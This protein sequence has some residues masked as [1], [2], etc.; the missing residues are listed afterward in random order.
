[1]KVI[2]IT[3]GCPKNQDDTRH[4][5]SWLMRHGVELTNSLSEADA[6]IIHTCSFIEDAK[7]ESI[8]TILNMTRDKKPG[9]K[10]FVTGCLVQQHG[11]ELLTEFPEV[12]AFLGTGQIGEILTLLKQT[13]KG[14]YL[15]RQCPGGFFDPDGLQLPMDGK[16]TAYLRIIEGCD[17]ICSFCVIP[18]LRGPFRSRT[19]KA[20]LQEAAVLKNNGVQEILVIGQDTG[21]WGLDAASNHRLPQLLQ[22]L[23]TMGFKWIR[24]MYMHPYSL[25]DDTILILRESP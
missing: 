17:H 4:L 18:Q 25:S 1:M 7:R 8:E 20:I 19:E 6:I 3:L 16:K 24:L 13:Q 9:A 14:Q 23:R 11:R 15:N 22:K 2:V 21:A 5:A 12:D 10:L